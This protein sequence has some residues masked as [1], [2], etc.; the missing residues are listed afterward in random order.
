M[1]ITCFAAGVVSGIISIIWLAIGQLVVFN[2]GMADMVV[3]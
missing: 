1:K 2:S 3:A